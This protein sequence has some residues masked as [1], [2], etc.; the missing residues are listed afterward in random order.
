VPQGVIPA[1]PGAWVW[2]G[3]I[4]YMD[5]PIIDCRSVPHFPECNC[6]PTWLRRPPDQCYAGDP[7][8]A[9]ARMNHQVGSSRGGKSTMFDSKTE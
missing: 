8:H 4:A 7:V 2:V 9:Q 3:D 6:T 1:E 5:D